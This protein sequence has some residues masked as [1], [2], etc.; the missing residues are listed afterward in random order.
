MKTPVS[1]HMVALLILGTCGGG[2][3]MFLTLQ[4]HPRFQVRR[5]VFDGVPESRR[6][7]PVRGGLWAVVVIGSGRE[8]RWGGIAPAP[9]S[10]RPYPLISVQ[11]AVHSE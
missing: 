1:P 3:A 10:G 6:A 9:P 8:V 4:R 7:T 2:V 11:A 5:I